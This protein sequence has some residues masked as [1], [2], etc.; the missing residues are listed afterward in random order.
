[1]LNAVGL[2]TREDPAMQSVTV[3]FFSDLCLRSQTRIVSLPCIGRNRLHAAI[4]TIMRGPES[5]ACYHHPDG[6]VVALDKEGVS[7]QI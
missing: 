3:T 7:I 6:S 1:M 5:F 2:G 4:R